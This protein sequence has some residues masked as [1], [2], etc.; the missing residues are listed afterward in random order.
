[1]LKIVDVKYTKNKKIID[2]D[3]KFVAFIKVQDDEDFIKW[4]EQ[5]LPLFNKNNTIYANR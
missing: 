4:L 5:N 3:G 1:M 2:E